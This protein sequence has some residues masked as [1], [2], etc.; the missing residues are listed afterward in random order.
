MRHFHVFVF[1]SAIIVV[2][3]DV[4][5][6]VELAVLDDVPVLVSND[7]DDRVA[8]IKV[9]APGKEV[10]ELFIATRIVYEIAFGDTLFKYTDQRAYDIPENGIIEIQLEIFALL[11]FSDK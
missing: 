5:A 1:F 3:N 10:L 4:A 2:T 6:E 11:K 7:K 8:Y 9:R